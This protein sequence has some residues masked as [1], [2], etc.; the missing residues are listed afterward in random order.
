LWLLKHA[1]SRR[2]NRTEAN[3]M[4]RIGRKEEDA[5]DRPLKL[6]LA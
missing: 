6:Q 3:K 2:E 5:R 1:F 4:K